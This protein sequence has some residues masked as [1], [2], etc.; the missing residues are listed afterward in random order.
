MP[1]ESGYFLNL[2]QLLN[3]MQKLDK[4]A[5]KKKIDLLIKKMTAE[6]ADLEDLAKPIA[7][8]NSIGRV[9]RMDAIN[10]KGVTEAALRNKKSR[11]GA[12]V[13][14]K[15]RLDSEDFGYCKNCKNLI[16][17]ARLMYLPESDYCVR[18]AR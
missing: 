11:L 4:E 15:L 9:S 5:F 14:A 6:V 18:C 1:I 2:R 13:T 10:N 17:E 16:Q 12:L 7:P 3:I 8:E